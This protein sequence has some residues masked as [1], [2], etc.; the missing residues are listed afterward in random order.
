VPKA[1]VLQVICERLLR[2]VV[3][4]LIVVLCLVSA[5]S[6]EWKEKVLY[7]FQGTPDAATPVGGVVFDQQGN[8]YGA[9]NGGP[10]GT[11]GTVY[12][13]SPPVKRGGSWTEKVLY[14]FL[15]K[16]ENDGQI[17]SGGLIIDG[18]GNLYGVTAYGGAGG[19]LLLGTLVGCG[20]VYELSPP[21]QKGGKWTEKI[22]YS[23]QGGSDGYYP[24]G[25][26]VF[27]KAGNLYGATLFGGG[28]GTCDQ[29][30][31]LYCG[32]VFKLSP[33]KQKNGA[34]KEKVLYSFK[35]VDQGKQS[36]DGANPAGNL[37]LDDKGAIYGTTYFGGDNQT[38]TCAGGSGG[39]GCGLVFELEPPT[40]NGG[41]WK[42]KMLH[43]FHAGTDDGANP[44]GGV[45][46][47]TKGNLFGT[48]FF[49]PKEG[50]GVV[51]EVV[52][53]PQQSH[54]WREQVLYRFVDGTDGANPDA[55]LVIGADGGLYGTA[56]RGSFGS[57][58][59]DV[60]RLRPPRAK[61]KAWTFTTL[62]GFG[63]GNGQNGAGPVAPLTLDKLGNLYGTTQYG[64]TGQ[65]CQGGCGTVF[66]VS[67]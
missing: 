23:F 7:S 54:E 18:T 59:G 39:T 49:G 47:D 25:T 17:P 67:P 62:F 53:P 6:A 38:G 31:Y 58:Y 1:G 24:N 20:T 55:G 64:G 9:A 11:Q 3:F 33:P 2:T 15:G 50:Y 60:F 21:T 12:Q 46:S 44:V 16:G 10:S 41:A 51:F 27:D 29:N 32:T 37:V 43:R 28:F 13:L 66:V 63:D 22:L 30:I 57:Q 5:A 26:L 61:V 36:G 65:R 48:T 35:G 42:E 8:L 34:W 4:S 56:Y 52:K 40:E 19:C 14:A 45:V